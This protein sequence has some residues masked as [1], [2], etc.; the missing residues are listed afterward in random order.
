MD[1]EGMKNIENWEKWQQNL[2][3]AINLGERIG[4][5]DETIGKVAKRVG[6]FLTNR[7]DPE[8]PQQ[9]LL[10]D[11]WEVADDDERKILT[12]VLVKHLKA[13]F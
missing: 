3:T 1:L 5:N 11:L 7:V 10:K 2:H 9:R 6:D 12:K 4:L 8:N 13:D